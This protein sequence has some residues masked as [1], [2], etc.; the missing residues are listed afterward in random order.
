MSC[1]MGA[2]GNQK[3]KWVSAVR[4]RNTNR[5]E[6]I[7]GSLTQNGFRTKRRRSFRLRR[8]LGRKR[9]RKQGAEALLQDGMC[10]SQVQHASNFCCT[11]AL[12]NRRETLMPGPGDARRRQD[13]EM[14]GD[15]A[16]Y[17]CVVRSAN[18][19]GLAKSRFASP[20]PRPRVQSHKNSSAK[21]I[22]LGCDVGCLSD[23]LEVTPALRHAAFLLE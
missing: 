22:P 12:F 15:P 23:D 18:G 2:S 1:G 20:Q 17:T 10:A 7:N 8:S 16:C 21:R 6:T 19:S 9:P 3:V 13:S 14:V 11:A 5:D 4:K